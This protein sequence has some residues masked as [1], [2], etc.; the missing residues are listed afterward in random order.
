MSEKAVLFYIK[1]TTAGLRVYQEVFYGGPLGADGKREPVGGG[2][3]Q[4]QS[5]VYQP[6]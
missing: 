1:K 3:G 6:Q 5:G 4:N 2:G